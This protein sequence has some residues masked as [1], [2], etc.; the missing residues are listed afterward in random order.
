MSIWILSASLVILFIWLL[1]LQ[2]QLNA[3][4]KMNKNLLN[5]SNRGNISSVI[6]TILRQ[7]TQW[8]T[9]QQEIDQFIAFTKENMKF[10]L[11]EGGFVRYDS[12]EGVGGKQSFSVLLMTPE[13]D[14]IMI[15]ALHDRVGTKMYAKEIIQ[16]EP[17]QNLSREEN[18]LL[19]QV[20]KGISVEKE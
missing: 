11:R 5:I 15:S 6:E 18:Q 2:L 10:T 8:Q 9:K 20:L 16:G 7:Y 4:R 14:G 19:N 3:I 17:S 1:V 12:F 13:Y